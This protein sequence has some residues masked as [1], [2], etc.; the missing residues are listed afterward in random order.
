MIVSDHSPCP[1]ELKRLDE[2]RFDLA[3][4]GISS[5]QLGLPVIW[6][7]ASRRGF[8]I[9]DVVRWMATEP[10]KLIDRHAGIVVG[11]PA[12]LVCFDPD[13]TWTV[14]QAKL[15][16]K[17]SLTPYHGATLRGIVQRTWVHGIDD[18]APQGK[19]H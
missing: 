15:F 3:W 6:T 4:G 12:H 11:Q 17:H 13:A 8:Q 7:E 10:A 2:G 19:V 14:D 1:P 16:H 5:L 9:T 18:D